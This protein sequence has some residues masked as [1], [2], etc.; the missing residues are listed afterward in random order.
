MFFS[1]KVRRRKIIEKERQE[2]QEIQEK[3]E[4]D[5]KKILLML[6]VSQ[7]LAVGMKVM[8]YC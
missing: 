7:N 5:K 2:I 3:S 6:M 8:M 1:V 4:K